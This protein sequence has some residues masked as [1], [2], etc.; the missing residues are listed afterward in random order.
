[1]M[2]M[3]Q[4]GRRLFLNK[5]IFVIISSFLLIVGFATNVFAETKLPITP[6]KNQEIKPVSSETLF[7]GLL[8]DLTEIVKPVYDWGIFI[9]TAIFIIGSIVMILSMI[10]KNGQWQ[11]Y[12]QVTMFISFVVM[13]VLRGFPILILSVKSMGDV[14]ILLTKLV[15]QLSG[16]A[17]FLGLTGI[18]ASLLFRFFYKLIEHPDFH[19]WSKNLLGVSVI[20][21]ISSIVIP[22]LFPNL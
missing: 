20:M 11:K 13:L 17:V 3:N 21:M 6:K 8:K 7:G 5:Y 10:V 16:A 14:N 15:S 2:F 9:I 1:M 4:N 22:I 19:R 12:A 18:A